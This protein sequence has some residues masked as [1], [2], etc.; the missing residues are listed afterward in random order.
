MHLQKFRLH[1]NV[2]ATS[3]ASFLTDVSS[4]MVT[5]TLPLFMANVLGI[6][7]VMI[8]VIEG[9]AESIASLVKLYSG[10][11]SDRL[12]VRKPLAV[13]GYSVS[14]LAKPF[15]YFATSWPAV[16]AV[17]WIDRLGKGIRT[18]PRDA[19]IADSV[20]PERR[21][22]AFGFHRAA[23]TAGAVLG[24]L[25][26]VV[27][28][29]S[30]QAAPGL[31]DRSTFQ[32]LVL[33][34]VGPAFLAVLVL[35]LGARDVPVKESGTSGARPKV[36]FSGMGRPFL[37]FLAFSAIFDIGNS[38][39]AFLILRAQERGLSVIGVLWTLLAFNF[40]YTLVSTPAGHLSDRIPRRR[41]IVGGWLLYSLTY[42]GFAAA[43]T[44]TH[45]VG[46][47]VLYGLYYGLVAGTAK[48]FIADL[49]PAGRRATAF[50]TYHAVLG[51][52]N[53]PASIIAGVLWQGLG[54]WA[55]FGASAPFVFGAGTALLAA[56]LLGL[57]L[58]STTAMGSPDPNRPVSFRQDAP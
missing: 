49:V 9:F 54:G 50:G 15:L 45:I 48:A 56:V 40:V 14:S 42:L 39:D 23:D 26:S 27:V 32:L 53:L 12:G 7:T 43:Q 55:G 22:L 33:A 24:L 21:G 36:S 41:V 29:A 51:L 35:M 34:S 5:N 16:A 46:A 47:Y 6:G 3:A 2:W 58:P 38:S 37:Y 13:A 19:L 18:A 57:F 1:R 44:S 4:E 28:V 31:L 52:L 8:G 10:V 20:P 25:I 11:L 17:R 30:V